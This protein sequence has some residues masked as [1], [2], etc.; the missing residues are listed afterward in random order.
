VETPKRF[1]EA[2]VRR[3]V[4]ELDDGN[5]AEY[6]QILRAKGI[7]PLNDGRWLHFDYVPGEMDFRYGSADYTGRLCVIGCKINQPAIRELFG[8]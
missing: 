5:G 1:E 8:I 4:E 3:A 6:G 7:L 2:D